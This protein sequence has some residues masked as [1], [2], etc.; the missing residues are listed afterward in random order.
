M[1]C[2]RAIQ[3]AEEGPRAA[4]QP[5]LARAHVLLLG[6]GAGPAIWDA[7]H[8]SQE[9]ELGQR[10]VMGIGLGMTGSAPFAVFITSPHVKAGH[11]GGPTPGLELKLVPAQGKTEARYT[12]P[13]ITPGHWRNEEATRECLDQEAF[14]CTGDAVQWIDE[15]DLHQGL[16]FDGASP[17]TSSSPR[18]PS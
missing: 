16:R 11:I 13:N 5:A 3:S 6:R 12:G 8:E 10:I 9:R 1:H 4:P 2:E 15:N 17:R 7:L 18:A 14:F